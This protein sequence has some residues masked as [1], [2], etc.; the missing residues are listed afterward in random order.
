M[1]EDVSSG[2]M[3]LKYLYGNA[4]CISARESAWQC[5]HEG[6]QEL[7]GAGANFIPEAT[8]T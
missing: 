3:S 5:C 2:S 6:L 8:R 7:C 4:Y 1:R